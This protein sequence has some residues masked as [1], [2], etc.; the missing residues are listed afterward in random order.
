MLT[1]L[2]LF[3]VW[4][5]RSNNVLPC[6]L[7]AS[8]FNNIVRDMVLTDWWPMCSELLNNSCDALSELVVGCLHEAFPER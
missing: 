2:P 1:W 3:V 7:S 8:L 5:R 6:F 4:T